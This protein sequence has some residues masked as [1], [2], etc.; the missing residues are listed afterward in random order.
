MSNKSA[1]IAFK[2]PSDPRFVFYFFALVDV[3]WSRAYTAVID[4]TVAR[5]YRRET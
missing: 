2:N 1:T 4:S 5:R 3:C